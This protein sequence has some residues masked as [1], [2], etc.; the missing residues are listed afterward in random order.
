MEV[1]FKVRV[2]YGCVFI[3]IIFDRDPVTTIETTQRGPYLPVHLT[4]KVF[5]LHVGAL[6]DNDRVD[7][8]C[9]EK[10]LLGFE[11]VGLLEFH[12]LPE[13]VW[14]RGRR[15]RV[16]FVPIAPLIQVRARVRA[17]LDI[18]AIHQPALPIGR[19]TTDGLEGLVTF[20]LRQP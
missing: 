17:I 3:D 15:Y 1:G 19:E 18:V 20:I 6:G 11:I 2:L 9:A 5:R 14:W 8:G 16:R 12:G 4:V 7:E 10:C 13:I